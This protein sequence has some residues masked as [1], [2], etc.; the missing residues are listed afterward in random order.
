MQIQNMTFLEFEARWE[1]G[2]F[3]N[4]SKDDLIEIINELITELIDERMER[5]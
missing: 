4:A 5:E 2:F 3:K 1:C